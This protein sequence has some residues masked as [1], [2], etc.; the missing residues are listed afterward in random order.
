[1]TELPAV[2]VSAGAH[3]PNTVNRSSRRS[4][5]MASLFALSFGGEGMAKFMSSC[6]TKPRDRK[7]AD[8]NARV[9]EKEKLRQSAQQ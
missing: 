8:F 5:A 3:G 4:L 2:Y 6:M 9:A 7:K 1:M